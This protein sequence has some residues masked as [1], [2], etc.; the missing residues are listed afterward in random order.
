MVLGLVWNVSVGYQVD[1]RGA[2]SGTSRVNRGGSWLNVASYC[3]VAFRSNNYPYYQVA[4]SVFVLFAP[5]SSG[6]PQPADGPCRR[7]QAGGGYSC[8]LRLSSF[9]AGAAKDEFF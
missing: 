2:A 6:S 3:T 8:R 5:E 7:R 4:T 9:A 1:Y